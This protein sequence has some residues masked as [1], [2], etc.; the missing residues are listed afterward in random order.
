MEK[1]LDLKKL[2]QIRTKKYPL[3]T[4]YFTAPSPFEWKE[5]ANIFIKSMASKHEKKL[6]RELLSGFKADIEEIKNYINYKLGKTV[7]SFAFFVCGKENLFEFYQ[8][9]FPI[10]N[11]FY[12]GITPYLKPLAKTLDDY[13]KYILVILHVNYSCI[14]VIDR[15][16]IIEGVCKEDKIPVKTR[17]AGWKNLE[18]PR[19]ERRRGEHIK[20]HYKDVAEI[21]KNS[22]DKRISRIIIAG[23]KKNASM[24]LNYLPN[25]L[26]NIVSATFQYDTHYNDFKIIEKSLEVEIESEVNADKKLVK[27]LMEEFG[28]EKVAVGLYQVL[29]ALQRG[30]IIKLIIHHKFGEPGWLCDKC[31]YLGSGRSGTC[32]ICKGKMIEIEDIVD[33]VINKAINY[34]IDVDFV[35]EKVFVDNFGGIAAILRY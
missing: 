23:T 32:P 3:I 33:E 25:H 12:S 14:Y 31:G 5:K 7:K 15:T 2:S 10:T 6:S 34:D 11:L 1:R 21:V 19:A 24:F 22:M 9:P 18:K 13:G 30:Q 26:K 16:E 4:F 8:V 27:Q 17:K 29:M 28:K 20:K 35:S